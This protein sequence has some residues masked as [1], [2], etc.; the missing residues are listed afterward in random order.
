MKFNKKI[1]KMPILLKDCF[2]IIFPYETFH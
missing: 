1:P 2:Q